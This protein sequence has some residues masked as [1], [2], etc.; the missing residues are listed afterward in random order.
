QDGDDDLVDYRARLE[1]GEVDNRAS[2]H[3]GGAEGGA[4]SG[5][6]NALVERA[7]A[8]QPERAKEGEK[9]ASEDE[10]RG[11]RC[12]HSI[13]SPRSRNLAS[14]AV[15]TKPSMPITSAASK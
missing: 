6:V 4:H 7:E 5:R 9:R 1:G 15:E 14:A 11:D 3:E 2:E 8:K 10:K 13:T 12:A